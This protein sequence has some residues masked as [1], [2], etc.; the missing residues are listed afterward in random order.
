MS[1]KNSPMKNID[2]FSPLRKKSTSTQKSKDNKDIFA[3][4]LG[5][6]NNL[7]TDFKNKNKNLHY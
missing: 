3:G 5:N 7:N 6:F 1:D 4:D 2:S